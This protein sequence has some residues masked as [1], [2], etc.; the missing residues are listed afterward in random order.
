MFM[1]FILNPRFISTSSHSEHANLRQA[2]FG[3]EEVSSEALGG[4]AQRKWRRL[5]G[6]WYDA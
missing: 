2:K 5:G 4:R 1:S 6:Q 3:T